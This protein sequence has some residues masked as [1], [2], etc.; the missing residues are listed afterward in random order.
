M[1]WS[2]AFSLVCEVAF[3]RQLTLVS[4][5]KKNY[6]CDVAHFECFFLFLFLFPSKG[7][8]WNYL[9]SQST[10]VTSCHLWCNMWS[11]VQ[12]RD[13]RSSNWWETCKVVHTNSPLKS[14]HHE[15]WCTWRHE[16]WDM[17]EEKFWVIAYNSFL[18][19]P[20]YGERDYHI[21]IYPSFIINTQALK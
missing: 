19:L 13:M 4:I 3:G 6:I 1:Q 11:R 2:R 9:T 8:T 20:C 18:S 17:N 15:S 12:N 14:D 21:Q 16:T 10:I 5:K 7:G